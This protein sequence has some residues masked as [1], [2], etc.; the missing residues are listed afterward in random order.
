MKT[1]SFI[2]IVVIALLLLA[3]CSADE[4]FNPDRETNSNSI[5][6]STRLPATRAATFEETG[7]NAY[8]SMGIYATLNDPASNL[9]TNQEVTRTD[10]SNGW[11]YTPLAQ[12]P[13]NDKSVAFYAYAPFVK[14]INTPNPSITQTAGGVPSMSYTVPATIGEKAASQVDLLI[15]EAVSGHRESLTTDVQLTM[16]HVLTRIVFSARTQHPYATDVTSIQISKIEITGLANH[17]TRQMDALYTW[18]TPTTDSKQSTDYVLSTTGGGLASTD[19]NNATLTEISTADGNLYLMPQKLDAGSTAQLKITTNTVGGTKP[20]PQTYTFA[21]ADLIDEMKQGESL[22]F[23]LTVPNAADPQPFQIEVMHLDWNAEYDIDAEIERDPVLYISN[24]TVYAYDGAVTCVYFSSNIAPNP[25]GTYND[26]VFIEDLGRV[27]SSS[28]T[29]FSVKEEFYAI[30]QN[31]ITSRGGSRTDAAIVTTKDS[32]EPSPPFINNLRYEYDATTGLYKGHLDIVQC[33]TSTAGETPNEGKLPLI[34]KLHVGKLVRDITVQRVVTIEAAK[35]NP[36]RYVGTFHRHNE[37]GERLVTWHEAETTTWRVEIDNTIGSASDRSQLVLDT[38]ISPDFRNKQLYTL[39]ARDPEGTRVEHNPNLFGQGR[40]YFRVGWKTPTSDTGGKNRYARIVVKLWKA[41]ATEHNA[42]TAPSETYYLYCRQGETEEPIASAASHYALFNVATPGEFTRYPTQT[43]MLYQWN[44]TTPWSPLGFNAPYGWEQGANAGYE[45]T[46]NYERDV[47][48]DGYFYPG[49]DQFKEMQIVFK[50]ENPNKERGYY[51]DGYFDRRA[52]TYYGGYSSIDEH[53]VNASQSEVGAI[54]TL[55]FNNNSADPNSRACRSIFLVSGGY[56]STEVPTY[57]SVSGQLVANV[58]H[59]S[60]HGVHGGYW[61][62]Y[63]LGASLDKVAGALLFKGTDDSWIKEY[64]KTNAFSVRCVS[65]I[66]W[67]FA[68]DPNGGENGPRNFTISNSETSVTLP[69]SIPN[70]YYRDNYEFKGWNTKKDGSGD[71]YLAGQ[72]I[73]NLAQTFGNA[74]NPALR[75]NLYAQWALPDIRVDFT[76]I[77]NFN[78]YCYTDQTF[79]PYA[80]YT[81]TNNGRTY[82]QADKWQTASSQFGQEKA[83]PILDFSPLQPKADFKTAY[84]KCKKMAPE[85]SWR[86][87]RTQEIILVTQYSPHATTLLG[88]INAKLYIWTGTY[89]TTSGNALASFRD[90]LDCYTYEVSID[91]LKLYRCVRPVITP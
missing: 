25:D 76:S 26:V 16:R 71:T 4:L 8:K 30:A 7:T 72:T 29:T 73:S 84:D 28:G 5:I 48:P 82:G 11:S 55:L 18:D 67:L 34:L 83:Y 51:A 6:F 90:Y 68:F 57:V 14:Q 20:G 37:T 9:L 1:T 61:F 87:P 21:L 66:S 63:S 69:T 85:G 33:K 54:G 52:V 43:G 13:A 86:L 53:R 91:E 49:E 89:S 60:N 24:E 78:T 31:D 62:N 38:R 56:R 88:A 70:N 39:V 23:L 32:P 41:P 59:N 17:S 22:R 75:I 19:L 40:V 46:F 15:S 64:P 10:G 27:S 80:G 44:R 35:Q 58:D 3:G 81:I 50:K 77:A 79:D 47:C 45:D 36:T 65:A 42:P 12:W 2:P 74:T